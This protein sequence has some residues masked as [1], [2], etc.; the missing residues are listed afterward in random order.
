MRMVNLRN[1]RYVYP[2]YLYKLRFLLHGALT[3]RVPCKQN[4]LHRYL[5]RI[6]IQLLW[7]HSTVNWGTKIKSLPRSQINKVSLTDP[8][9]QTLF[10][11]L[12]LPSFSY[13]TC[14]Y[15]PQKFLEEFFGL[16]GW[17]EKNKIT[18]STTKQQHLYLNLMVSTHL[19][20]STKLIS[21][22]KK[23]QNP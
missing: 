8:R 14:I 11:R 15:N 9:F 16:S 10:L 6:T 21:N 17:K 12:Q 13:F 3:S 20:L 7:L 1:I 19:F 23:K 5:M 22:Q 18:L 4:K 2:A